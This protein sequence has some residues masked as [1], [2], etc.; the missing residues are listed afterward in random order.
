MIC[1]NDV[2]SIRQVRF[3]HS[4][5]V[6]ETN[7]S[8]GPAPNNKNFKCSFFIAITEQQWV[9]EWEKQQCHHNKKDA[10]ID[11]PN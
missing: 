2:R 5:N 7:Y 4:F 10:Y 8:E 11:L 6:V 1:Q 9:N 3:S